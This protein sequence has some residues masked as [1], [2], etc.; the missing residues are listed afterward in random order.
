MRQ[1]VNHAPAPTPPKPESRVE[2]GLG[3]TGFLEY[4]RIAAERFAVSLERLARV[5]EG[6]RGELGAIG[7]ELDAQGVQAWELVPVLIDS[8]ERPFQPTPMRKAEGEAFL[9]QVLGDRAYARYR[10]PAH[11]DALQAAG[12]RVQ[13]PRALPD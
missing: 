12:P 6:F 4:P 9:A 8:D 13:S 2:P 5:R 10:R 7:A 1:P 3:A 11:D